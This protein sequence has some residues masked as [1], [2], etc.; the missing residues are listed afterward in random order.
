MEL[1]KLFLEGGLLPSMRDAEGKTPLEQALAHGHYGAAAFLL[2]HR[3]GVDSCSEEGLRPMHFAAMANDCNLA[4]RLEKEGALL[5]PIDNRN[6]M[7]VHYAA[8]MGNCDMLNWCLDRVPYLGD[9][10]PS[11]LQVAA[12][13]KRSDAMDLIIRRSKDIRPNPIDIHAPCRVPKTDANADLSVL[14]SFQRDLPVNTEESS[15]LPM[16]WALEEGLPEYVDALRRAGVHPTLD[17]E[18]VRDYWYKLSKKSTLSEGYPHS[19]KTVEEGSTP[20]HLAARAGHLKVCEAL[21]MSAVAFEVIKQCEENYNKIAYFFLQNAVKE[22]AHKELHIK[23]SNEYARLKGYKEEPLPLEPIFVWPQEEE[24]GLML[25]DDQVWQLISASCWQDY[26][27]Q[28]EKMT[29]SLASIL[30][31]GYKKAEKLVSRERILDAIA[32]KVVARVEAL[33]A[34][35]ETTTGRRA[36]DAAQLMVEDIELEI[37]KAEALKLDAEKKASDAADNARTE[38]NSAWGAESRGDWQAAYTMRCKAQEYKV[39]A[40]SFNKQAE[41]HKQAIAR[42]RT[43]HDEGRRL[44]DELGNAR[45]YLPQ[46][47]SKWLI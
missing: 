39:E 31:N 8:H 3:G 4:D 38:R 9:S 16:I 15:A 32:R 40:A 11:I 21:V 41:N 1:I 47:L 10:L 7:P 19:I 12:V 35:R 46:L 33:L 45:A 29:M 36:S 20:L 28:K 43:R 25:T 17:G 2:S 23:K 13:A 24:V 5:H 6:W 42:D 37:D 27:A 14:W 26:K 18:L 34:V 30:K 22:H 44:R